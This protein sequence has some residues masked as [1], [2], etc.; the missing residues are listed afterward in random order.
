MTNEQAERLI[1]MLEGMLPLALLPMRLDFYSPEEDVELKVEKLF[2]L[3][4]KEG[5]DGEFWVKVQLVP[6]QPWVASA[7]FGRIRNAILGLPGIKIVSSVRPRIK[8]EPGSFILDLTNHEHV[9]NSF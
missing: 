2:H 7:H 4:L 5:D 9:R 3:V 1:S 6:M 8:K